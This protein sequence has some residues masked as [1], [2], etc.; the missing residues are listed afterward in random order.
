MSEQQDNSNIL[1]FERYICHD[2]GRSNIE[3]RLRIVEANVEVLKEQVANIK[4]NMATKTD[5]ANLKVWIFG[6]LLTAIAIATAIDKI[7]S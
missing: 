7:F 5:I 2:K 6:S 1:H 4:E 3:G